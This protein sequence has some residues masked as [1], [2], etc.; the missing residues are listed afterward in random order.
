M[1]EEME[2]ELSPEELAELM[3][4]YKKELAHIYRTA[5]AKRA[6]FSARGGADA[7]RMLAKSGEEM[8]ADIDAL[9]KKYGIHY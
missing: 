5:A 2:E 8:R 7:E 9:K 1:R 6:L 3:R 4:A